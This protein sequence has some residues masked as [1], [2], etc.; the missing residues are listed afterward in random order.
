MRASGTRIS[1]GWC[2]KSSIQ[3]ERV[4]YY[5]I[6][7]S[8]C[9]SLKILLGVLRAQHDHNTDT[10]RFCAEQTSN[11]AIFELRPTSVHTLRI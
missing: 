11:E 10:V 1:N 6:A 3:K 9:D 7:E 5:L 4:A 8:S 2:F